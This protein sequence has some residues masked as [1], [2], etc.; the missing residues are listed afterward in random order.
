MID[1]P[2][3]PKVEFSEW[4]IYKKTKNRGRTTVSI[5]NYG[6]NV[7]LRKWYG[8]TSVEKHAS[9]GRTS[10]GSWKRSYNKTIELNDEEQADKIARR[11]WNI[12]K[13]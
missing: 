3:K 13:K 11:L 7:A 8:F 4:G 6:L 9:G 10:S 1:M 12:R 5:W 2:R